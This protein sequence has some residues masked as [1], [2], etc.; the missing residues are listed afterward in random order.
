M[1]ASIK[2][3]IR[4]TSSFWL[5]LMMSKQFASGAIMRHARDQV[6]SQVENRKKD[7]LSPISYTCI[8]A[9]HVTLFITLNQIESAMITHFLSHPDFHPGLRSLL[10][11]LSRRDEHLRLSE[12]RTFFFEDNRHNFVKR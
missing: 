2:G 11:H 1:N 4:E 3:Q 8:G 12:K 7:D 9:L 10:L 6:T 5:S